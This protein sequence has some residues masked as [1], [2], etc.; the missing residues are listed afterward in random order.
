MCECLPT[1]AVSVVGVF[2]A[3]PH[4][5]QSRSE[6]IGRR[7]IATVI[8]RQLSFAHT[9]NGVVER[10]SAHAAANLTLLI[11]RRSLV[12]TDFVRPPSH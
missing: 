2:S 1:N 12:R 6:V 7:R 9:P 8:N 10:H 5:A 11:C 4:A 3:P